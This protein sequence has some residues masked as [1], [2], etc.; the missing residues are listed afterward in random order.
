MNKVENYL[1]LRKTEC[2]ALRYI[3]DLTLPEHDREYNNSAVTYLKEREKKAENNMTTIGESFVLAYYYWTI[4]R[5]ERRFSNPKVVRESL[6]LTSTGFYKRFNKWYCEA[7]DR[8]MS[9][10]D[11]LN[12]CKVVED[13]INN[14]KKEEFE[15]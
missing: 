9:S 7:F 8:V 6:Y 1:E 10:F 5:D 12:E 11:E 15:L 3:I 2:Q 13:I 14:E 4:D